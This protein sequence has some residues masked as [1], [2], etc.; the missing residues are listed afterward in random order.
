MH[1]A[2]F[3]LTYSGIRVS[4]SWTAKINLLITFPVKYAF[5]Y[6]LL[7]NFFQL[8]N[9]N[10]VLFC[11]HFDLPGFGRLILG[12]ELSLSSESV[13]SDPCRSDSEELLFSVDC[14]SST[15]SGEGPR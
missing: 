2:I 8:L 15:N 9:R 11:S 1:Q 10:I 4:K 5:T 7:P 6:I 14:L 3:E 12:M 13:E